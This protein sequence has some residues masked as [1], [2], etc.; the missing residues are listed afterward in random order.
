MRLFIFFVLGLSFF[1]SCKKNT[2]N[3][4]DVS[5]ISVETNVLRTENMLFD[6]SNVNPVSESLSNLKTAHSSFYKIYFEEI[7]P[8]EKSDDESKLF[9]ALE[10]FRN[11]EPI[12]ELYAKVKETYSDQKAM[13]SA[14]NRAF[15]YYKYYF[16]EQDIPDI[17]T[18]ISEYSYQAFIFEG[19][20]GKDAIGLGLDMFINHVQNYKMIESD[21]PGFSDYITRS[22]NKDHLL[23]KTVDVLLTDLMGEPNGNRLLDYMIH[24]GKMMYIS[25]KILPFVNDTVITEYST[26][27]LNWCKDNELEMW[28]FFLEK[29]MFYETKMAQIAK[30][31][32]MSP[33]SPGMP[34]E[35]PGRT[36]NYIGLK[37]VEAFMEKQKD[38]SLSDLIAFTDAQQ[39]LE[40]S[41]YKPRRK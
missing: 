32:N 18:F 38:K 41:K 25:K 17:Y 10:D 29:N 19:N 7:L 21:N 2:E 22:W 16:P 31:I 11:A 27:Q 14:F 35:A 6:I 20:E 34:S 39:I 13:I 33:N 8:L 24:H 9:L 1:T 30:Y 28:A 3:T 4:P 23:K 40:V 5:H 12:K 15:K 36:A 26:E 37:I